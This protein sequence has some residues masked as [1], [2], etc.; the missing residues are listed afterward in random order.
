[1]RKLF[2]LFLVC[3][4]CLQ[5]AAQQV[6]LGAWRT[7]LPYNNALS[8]ASSDDEIYCAT[9]GGL[10]K[11]DVKTSEVTK[12]STIDGLAGTNTK[13]VAYDQTTNQFLVAYQNANL[14]LIK[15]QKIYHL[16]EIFDKTGLG[17]KAINAISFNN[18]NA[19]LSCGFGIVVYDLNKREVK[20]TY[21]LGNGNL[22][23]LNIAIIND[24]IFANT[25]DGVYEAS[26]ANPLLTDASSWKKHDAT[27]SY[28]NG[29]CSSLTAFNG[30]LYGLFTDGIYRYKD[31]LWQLTNIFR[32]NVHRL[33]TS[34][35]LLLAIAPFRVI[36]YD[37]QENIVENLS[38]LSTFD[39]VNDAIVRPN[40]SLYLAD[41]S[42]GLLAKTTSQEFKFLLP[43]GP[44]TIHVS[45]LKYDDGKLI[46]APG[47]ISTIYAPA[48][49]NDG[50]SQF[51]NGEWTSYS[52]KNNPAF[53]GIRDIVTSAF[54]ANTKTTYFGSYVNGV[55]AVDAGGVLKIFNQNNSTLQLTIGD[56]T[57]IRV[58]GLA[59]DS[60]NN[61]WVTQYGVNKPL[62]V[63]NTNGQWLSYDFTSALPDPVTTVTGLL[64]DKE[65]NKW[66][67]LR[68][69]GLLIFDGSKTRKVGFGNNNGAL[70]GTDVKCLVSDKDG[71]V[72]IGTDAGLAV[73]Y[74]PQDLL[75]GANVEIPN[76]VEGGFLKPLLADQNI[77]CIAV[78]GANRKW[79]GTNNGVW[80]FNPEGTKQILFFNK[81]NSP[82]LSNQVL[83]IAIDDES[84]E[85]FFG[86][87]NGIISYKGDATAPVAKM[88]KIIVYP[89]PVRPGFT[90]NI[91]IK[92]LAENANVKITDINGTLVYETTA[93]GGQ[94]TWNGKNFSGESAS[95]GVYLVLVV[96]KDGTDTAV[97]KILIVR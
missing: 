86:T 15:N 49:Y 52:D 65:D 30:N 11:V 44:N 26:L 20:D 19:Y 21:Y 94:A 77:N 8:V 32:T 79:M 88:S 27:K 40:N 62:S 63:K 56:P 69:N 25:A 85:V 6:A 59:F 7:H 4:Y 84:G 38:N 53:A 9:T 55:L 16:P 24:A 82:L 29:T 1:M 39:N 45:E 47:A 14:D 33:K 23:I 43:N 50:F 78:D 74:H 80:L 89:N 72:W 18:G 70:P 64:I 31:N 83:S 41:G 35:N 76:L 67:K 61:L 51:T 96:N 57:N 93:N 22:E 5:V 60:K 97:A 48:Y 3:G 90:G 58:N 75:N 91:G 28:P 54:D 34:N 42:K 2:F 37:Q 87:A 66:L 95:S 46:L 36:S 73:V 81:D 12:L 13:L 17:N 10:F 68:S 71:A 92:G